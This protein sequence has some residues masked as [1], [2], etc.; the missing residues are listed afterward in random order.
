MARSIATGRGK[1]GRRS[2][3]TLIELM[4]VM[5]LIVTLASIGLPTTSGFTGEFMALMG[6]FNFL[7]TLASGWLTDRIND[8]NAGY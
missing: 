5:A 6:A 8:R 7:G 4:V 2:G 1:R 3:F